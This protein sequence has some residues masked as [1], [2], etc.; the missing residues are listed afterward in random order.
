ML[1]ARWEYAPEPLNG[2]DTE[3]LGEEDEGMED[4]EEEEEEEEE[5]LEEVE[6]YPVSRVAWITLIT[7][8]HAS[9]SVLFILPS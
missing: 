4:E 1:Y 5:I 9:T 7:I 3:N 6:E 2:T 8:Y